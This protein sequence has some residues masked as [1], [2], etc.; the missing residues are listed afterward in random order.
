MTEIRHSWV[1]TYSGRKF[2]PLDPNPDDID[3]FDIAHALSLQTRYTGH[4]QK[5]YS[6]AEHSVRCSLYCTEE[7]AL[8]GLLHDASEA[9]ISDIASPLK[10]TEV[11][12]LYRE[13]EQRLMQ[14]IAEKYKL[15][16]PEPPAVKLIDR[17][18][19]STEARFLMG[20]L[21]ENWGG[22]SL[23]PPLPIAINPWLPIDAELQ[24]LG[25]F[26][27]LGGFHK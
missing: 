18:M 14:V 21:I 4:C 11:F 16:Y 9:Y 3:I 15:P 22:I 26:A 19:L 25:R 10:H 17:R 1:Q 12:S 20:N 24:F 13:A 2:Y 6:V 27:Q 8:W 5:F 23:P 7:D